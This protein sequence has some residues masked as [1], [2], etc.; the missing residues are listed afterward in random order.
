MTPRETQ[1]TDQGGTAAVTNV[2]D[3]AVNRRTQ[4]IA[5]DP[6]APPGAEAGTVVMRHEES[7]GLT[8]VPRYSFENGWRY[9]GWTEVDV[10]AERD[11][12]LAT[13]QELGVPVSENANGRVIVESIRAYRRSTREV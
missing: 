11:S 10:E 2:P 13:A 8:I 5:N 9:R 12:L 4:G 3:V 1:G 7:G 6:T